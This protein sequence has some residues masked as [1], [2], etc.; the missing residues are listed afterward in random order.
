MGKKIALV[1]WRAS[2][3]R[4]FGGLLGQGPASKVSTTSPG[5]RKTIP[6]KC[7]APQPRAPGVSTSTTRATPRAVGVSQAPAPGAGIA[8]GLNP[9][10]GSRSRDGNAPVISVPAAAAAS[11]FAAAGGKDTPAADFATMDSRAG[12]GPC[13]GPVLNTSTKTP[14]RRAAQTTAT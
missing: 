4:T 8:A 7:S 3:A 11:V 10:A 12:A 13:P 2:A 5:R 6:F 14:A 9:A 1:Q